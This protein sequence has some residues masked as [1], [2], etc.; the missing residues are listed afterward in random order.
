VGPTAAG[1]ATATQALAKAEVAREKEPRE[2]AYI[3]ALHSFFDSYVETDFQNYAERYACQGINLPLP[4][5]CSRL[6]A[7]SRKRCWCGGGRSSQG[8]IGGRCHIGC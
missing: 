3:R 6:E 8:P 2:A 7:W 4:L 1:V 5:R